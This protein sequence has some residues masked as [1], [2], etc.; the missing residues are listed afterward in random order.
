MPNEQRLLGFLGLCRRAGKL[1]FGFDMTVEAMR[2][3]TADSVLLS[4]DCSERTARN[5]KRIAEE[6]GTEILILPL[7]MDEIGYAV[8]KRAGVLAVCDSGFSK[9]IK[10]LLE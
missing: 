7:S 8:A 2:K 9:K 3:G 4:G 1:I 5:I 6:T 10:E